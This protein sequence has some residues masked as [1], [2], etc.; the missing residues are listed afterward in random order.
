MAE[1]PL[2]DARCRVRPVTLVA[3]SYRDGEVGHEERDV[4]EHD[5][6]HPIAMI[7]RPGPRYPALCDRFS[8]LKYT[9][10]GGDATLCDA[11]LYAMRQWHGSLPLS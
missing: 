5:H 7:A 4:S 6:H 2:G 10:C 1:A 3:L 11:L 9:Y 8:I